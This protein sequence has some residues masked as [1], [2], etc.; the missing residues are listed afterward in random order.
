MTETEPRQLTRVRVENLLGR[1]THD[2]PFDPEWNFVIIYGPNGIGK[3]RLFEL[4][5]ATLT[6]TYSD[7]AAIP[8][9][10]ASFLFSD[11]T[12]VEVARPTELRLN[13][14]AGTHPDATVFRI[15]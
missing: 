8:F 3:T 7:I 10:K 2:I 13:L 14:E 4:V 5:N 15:R 6:G 11:G 1:F 12:V 9:G